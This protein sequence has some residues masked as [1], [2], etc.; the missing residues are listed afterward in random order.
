MDSSDRLFEEV[1][2]NYKLD[3]MIL[4]KNWYNLECIATRYKH[5]IYK[6]LFKPP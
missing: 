3:L 6:N 4:E 2:I 5:L 1:R